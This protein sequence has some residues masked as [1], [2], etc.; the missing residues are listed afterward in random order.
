[1]QHYIING[2]V[3]ITAYYIMDYIHIHK[4]V[5]NMHSSNLK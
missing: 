5:N 2:Q 1:M 3:D 4:D